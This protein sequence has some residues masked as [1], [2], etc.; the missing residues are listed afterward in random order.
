MGGDRRS[1]LPA[2]L[3]EHIEHVPVRN[4]EHYIKGESFQRPLQPL[5]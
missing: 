1:D 5:L 3:P 4:N 2:E